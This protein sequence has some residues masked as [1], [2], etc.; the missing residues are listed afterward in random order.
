MPCM[1]LTWTPTG[2]NTLFFKM[3]QLAIAEHLLG[4]WQYQDFFKKRGDDV[5]T[6]FKID[7]VF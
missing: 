3:R 2:P 7:L 4:T 1:D 5:A 6:I